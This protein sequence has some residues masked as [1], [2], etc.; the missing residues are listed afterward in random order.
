MGD[1]NGFD[2]NDYQPMG[3]Y[4]PI[5]AGDYKAVATAR[6]WKTT[7]A[8]TGERLV[9][10]WQIVEGEHKER[11]LVV[12]L[13][14]RNPNDTAVRIA[15]SELSSIC[16]ACGVMNPNDSAELLNHPVILTVVVEERND[17]PGVFR[18]EIK[19]YA[20]ISGSSSQNFAG[21]P[22]PSSTQ[23]TSGNAAPWRK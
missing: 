4:T 19:S 20:S 10:T 15:N 7:K 11:I 14:L 21:T 1:L 13:N 5:P 12:G 6:E 23:Q 2:A 16:R 8:G 22:P 3:E 18:N 17:K 9:F